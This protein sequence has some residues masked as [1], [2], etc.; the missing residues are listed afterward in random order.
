MKTVGFFFDHQDQQVIYEIW[1]L[2]NIY[3]GLILVFL[4]FI[5][6]V[7]GVFF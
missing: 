1:T 5:Q 6:G 3:Q 7:F 4:F 2:I